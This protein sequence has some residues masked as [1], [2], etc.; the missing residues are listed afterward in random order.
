MAMYG[1]SPRVR[2]N[3]IHGQDER[4]TASRDGLS[5]RVRGN[6][7]PPQMQPYPGSYWSIPAGA[8]EPTA[9]KLLSSNGMTKPVYPRG[10][11]GTCNQR[12]PDI[13][14]AEKG[15]RSIPAGAGEPWLEMR[16]RVMGTLSAGV[17]PRGCGGTVIPGVR[18]AWQRSIP[19]GA[20]EPLPS[21]T[22]SCHA[23]YPRGCGGTA[24]GP[25]MLCQSYPRS[26][27]AGA[28]E[29]SHF[30]VTPHRLNWVYPRGCGGT[31]LIRLERP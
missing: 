27:P 25:A 20:G 29:P 23:V 1:L 14:L 28:G 5:P 12:R 4:S 6:P 3:R 15:A 8:G 22:C 21:A 13:M 2:G 9:R 11:G 10:C 7:N 31:S 17:Y 19:A 24:L 16:Y 30:P 26:I 18:R